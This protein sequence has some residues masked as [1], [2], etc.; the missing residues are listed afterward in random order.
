MSFLTI[1]FEV[2]QYLFFVGGT[3]ASLILFF[4]GILTIIFDQKRRESLVEKGEVKDFICGF[5]VVFVMGSAFIAALIWKAS[6]F[7][8]GIL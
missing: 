1:F 6:K 7:L 5:L 8:E 3:V 4:G 2:L